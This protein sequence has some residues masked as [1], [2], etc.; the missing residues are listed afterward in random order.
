MNLTGV[1]LLKCCAYGNC[2]LDTEDWPLHILPVGFVVCLFVLVWTA[3]LQ[4]HTFIQIHFESKQCL[5]KRLYLASHCAD[6]QIKH[7]G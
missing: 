1:A 4:V 2:L 6:I 3:V 5:E 7:T